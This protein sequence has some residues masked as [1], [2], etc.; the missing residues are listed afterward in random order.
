VPRFGT[1]NAQCM[2]I[3]RR[4]FLFLFSAVIGDMGVYAKKNGVIPNKE[5]KKR[6]K[7]VFVFLLCFICFF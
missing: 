2:Y 4:G 3:V 6:E 7:F 1:V 5:E